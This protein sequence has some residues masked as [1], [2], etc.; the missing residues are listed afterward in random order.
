MNLIFDMN[1]NMDIITNILHVSLN[2]FIVPDHVSLNH[3]GSE[4]LEKRMNQIIRN[5]AI[6]VHDL[7]DDEQKNKY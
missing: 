6:M 1:F 2:V 4:I 5:K 3:L 7:T